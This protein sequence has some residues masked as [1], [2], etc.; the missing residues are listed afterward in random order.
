M[1]RQSFF[2]CAASAAIIASSLGGQAFAQQAPAAPDAPSAGVSDTSNVGELVVTAKF[3]STGAESATKLDI[4]VMDTPYAVSAYS[5]TFLQATET[6]QVA[7]LY[8]YMT[9]VQRSGNTGYDMSVRG[10]KTTAAD[11]NAIMTDGL[12]G[13][14]VRFGSPPTFGADHV[15]LVK[16][17]ASLL[18]GQVEPGG[19]VNIISKKP[20][21]RAQTIIEA[22]GNEG[23]GSGVQHGD[24]LLVGFD[25]TGPIAGNDSLLYRFVAQVGDT[26][27]FRENS[28]ERPIYLAPSLTWNINDATSATLQYEYRKDASQYDNGLVVPLGDISKIA[29]IDTSYQAPGDELLEKGGTTSL[30]F[31]H[32]FQ[33]GGKLNFAF[34]DVRHT[35]RTTGFTPIGFVGAAQ[36]KL[37]LR[38]QDNTN[39]RGY[40]FGDLNF[41]QPFDTGPVAH[42]LIVGFNDG[43]ELADF[44]RTQYDQIPTSGAGSY[45]LDVYNP[46]YS[47]IPDRTSFPAG[48]AANLTHTHTVSNADGFYLSDFITFTDQWKAL[49]GVRYSRERQEFHE[50]RVAGTPSRASD[51]DDVL[52]SAGLVFEP[53][54]MLSFYTTYST[55]FVPVPSNNVDANNQSNFAPTTAQAV[56]AGVKADLFD[57][58]LNLT[59]DVF[60]ID[61]KNVT[62]TFTVGCPVSIGTCTQDTGSERSEGV[63]L[64]ANARPLP[65]WQIL[66]GVSHLNAT[67]VASTDPASVGARLANVPSDTAH[68]W[69]RYDITTGRFNGL[70][71]GLGVS[72]TGDRPGQVPTTKSPILLPL[73]AYTTADTAIYYE[74]KKLE[75]VFK[76]S[77]IFDV[78]YLEDVGSQGALQVLPGEPR[79]AELT[80]RTRF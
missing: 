64:E 42:R 33:G 25:S 67:V 45:T 9:G 1:T 28:Y 75:I 26:T 46:D 16:G 78:H 38:A 10:F 70:G 32:T 54:K 13:L 2:L 34:R 18:Y 56:E 43:R 72:Y 55:S 44:N 53:T 5:Q 59:A 36:T 52:P 14:T 24:G 66:A 62:S 3:L 21:D 6:T 39:T 79:K 76:V 31:S 19:F 50:L 63:E 61:K 23:L 30:Q 20:S 68:L 29:P 48:A 73:P 58:R 69:T 4:P 74:F 40:D 49:V 47:L 17:P 11:R 77:N 12:P 71:F 41:V 8:K 80:L 37:S 65:D 60:K 15:E 22:T 27:K 57:K 51:V 7:D 35:D